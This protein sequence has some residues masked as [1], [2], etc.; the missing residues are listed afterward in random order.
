[1]VDPRGRERIGTA[2]HQLAFDLVTERNRVA[3]LRRENKELRARIESLERELAEATAAPARKPRARKRPAAKTS[4]SS[5]AASRS[6]HPD[7]ANAPSITER[8]PRVQALTD[9]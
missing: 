5:A 7:D 6:P 3:A 1:V 8:L 9:S 2:L 4:L